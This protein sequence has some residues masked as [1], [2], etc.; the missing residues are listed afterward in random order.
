MLLSKNNDKYTIISN[1]I[2]EAFFMALNPH[3]IQIDTLPASNYGFYIKIDDEYEVDAERELATL[4]IE[5]IA[6]LENKFNKLFENGIFTSSL[7]FEV[8]NR[9]SGNK[10]DKDNVESLIALGID[11]INF[12]D[13]NGNFHNLSQAELSTLD[14]EMIQDGLGKYQWKWTKEA[15]VD[16]ADTFVAVQ[17]IEI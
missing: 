6:K 5:T 11:P 4:K 7:G 10:N 13:A 16:M 3:H 1:I 15:E 12:R 8:N 14:L 2:D 17:N 9:R